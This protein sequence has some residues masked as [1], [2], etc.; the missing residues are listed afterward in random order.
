[1]LVTLLGIVTFVRL[2]QKAKAP[3]PILVTL[4]GIVTFA[5]LGIGSSQPL[6]RG[7]KA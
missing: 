3:S 6:E 7:V 4:L 2:Q 1:M 5:G